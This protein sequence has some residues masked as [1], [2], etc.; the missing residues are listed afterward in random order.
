MTISI[1]II[2]SPTIIIFIYMVW[3]NQPAIDEWIFI[4]AGGFTIIEKRNRR[5]FGFFILVLGD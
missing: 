4:G 5:L 1:N 3:G 2:S